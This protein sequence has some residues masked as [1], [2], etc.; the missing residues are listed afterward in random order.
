MQR[1]CI[2]SLPEVRRDAGGRRRSLAGSALVVDRVQACLS[3]PGLGFLCALYRAQRHL[4]TRH[5]GSKRIDIRLLMR[6]TAITPVRRD[7]ITCC[8][9]HIGRS[10]GDKK[11]GL[12][13]RHLNAQPHSC[14]SE[15]GLIPDDDPEKTCGCRYRCFGG[16]FPSKRFP[17][18]AD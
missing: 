16:L 11:S 1:V 9:T 14:V 8:L 4:S 17:Q 10:R 18:D 5:C 3:G 2:R 12:R 6:Y 15:A 7:F 13:A